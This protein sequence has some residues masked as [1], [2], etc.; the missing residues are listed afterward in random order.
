MK[1]TA[2]EDGVKYFHIVSKDKAGNTG[3]KASHFRISIDTCALP[4]VISSKTHPE[5]ESWYNKPD[6][7]MTFAK[8]SD[9]SGIEGF[10][11]TVDQRPDTVP[12]ETNWVYTTATNI[13]IQGKPDGTW[14][15]HARSKDYA[16]N[17]STDAAHFKFN[18]DTMAL[19]PHV[20]SVSHPDISKWYTAKKAQF[21]ITAPEDAAGIEGYYYVL[22]NNARTIPDAS[23]TW[24]EN[25]TIFSGELQDGEW[26]L[27]V[28]SKDRATNIGTQAVHLKINID[29]T[30]KTPKVYSNTHPD[31]EI[32]Y[33]NA[34]PLLAWETPEDRSGIECYYYTIDNKTNTVPNKDIS[35]RTTSNQLAMPM[36]A[37]G[38]WY[39]HIVSKDKA[40][41]VG[42]EAAHYKMKIDTRVDAPKVE[43]TTHPEKDKWYNTPRVKLSWNVPQDLSKIKGFYYLLSKEKHFKIIP[44]IATFTDTKEIELYIEEEGTYY[45][46]IVCEDNAGNIGEEPEIYEIKVDLKAVAPTIISA[47]HPNSDRYYAAVNPVFIMD[48]I[49]DISGYEGF[50]Y[51][52]DK[53]QDTLPDKKN[54]KWTKD[55]TIKINEKLDDGEWYFHVVMKDKAGNLG[56]TAAVYKFK[57]ETK[58][59]ETYIKP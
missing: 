25:E 39:F 47:T 42:W 50:Y 43:S 8:T 51:L 45:F 9:L 46:H 6:A 7:E 2:T 34:M 38:I 3:T 57:I 15:V 4:P 59:P 13:E 18:I 10:F 55:T 17:I 1:F 22:D 35:E 56:T 19:P 48:K 33:N 27:H 30:A 28:V 40:G 41:N 20:V 26:Y 32:W 58:A 44:G 36:L 53:N 24:V 5:K 23:A 12:T 29:T 54:A 21:K 11:Y 49:D 14:F 52:V 31:Q 16:G 37:D